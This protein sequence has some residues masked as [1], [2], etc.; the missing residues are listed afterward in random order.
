MRRRSARRVSPRSLSLR[1]RPPEAASR[2]ASPHRAALR[3]WRIH[4]ARTWNGTRARLIRFLT[5]RPS[6]RCPRGADAR[7]S[8]TPGFRAT[9]NATDVPARRAPARGPS[10]GKMAR[11]RARVFRV[12]VG[13]YRCNNVLN[14]ALCKVYF[15]IVTLDCIGIFF[16]HFYQISNICILILF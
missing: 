4:V 1:P 14:V 5:R 6:R 11:V 3:S 10:S 7:R 12:T 16:S 8:D 15:F 9:R 13:T 2:L